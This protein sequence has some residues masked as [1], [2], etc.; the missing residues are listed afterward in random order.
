MIALEPAQ[1]AKLIDEIKRES[2]D[3]YYKH[4]ITNGGASASLSIAQAAGYL[5]ITTQTLRKLDIPYVDVTGNG[6]TI[7]YDVADLDA[8]KQKSKSK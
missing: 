1:E 2:V 8:H 4:L 6:G 3:K 5:N 7:Q